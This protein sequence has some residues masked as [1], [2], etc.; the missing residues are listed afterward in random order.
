MILIADSGSTKTHWCLI[1][2]KANIITQVTSKGINPFYQIES[3]I[4]ES[5]AT[6]VKPHIKESPSQIFFYGAGCLFDEKKDM[7]ARALKANFEQTES[8][9]IESDLLGAAIALCQKQ[10]G[11]ACILG[12][13]SNS[14]FYDGQ[15]ITHNVSPLGYILGDE[16]SGA[17]LGKRL[18]ADILKNQLSK[19]LREKFLSQYNINAATILENVYKRPFPNRFLASLSPFL[20]QNLSEPAIYEIVYTSFK[21]FFV[22]NIS[23]YDYT[24]HSVNLIGSVAWYY[25]EVLMEAAHDCNMTIGQ[26]VQ[27]PMQG[28]IKFHN[29]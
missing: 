1:D 20:A 19:E 5:I 21:E 16:G 2:L 10:P 28:L 24:C 9:R 3:E 27:S 29:K 6:Q 25:K 15:T 26:I 23:Q 12:T 22:R 13:G 14:C 7:V 18:V 4:L 17:V 11:I 8:I